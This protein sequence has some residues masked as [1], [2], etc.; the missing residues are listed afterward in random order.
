MA[1]KKA[2]VDALMLERARYLV[3]QLKSVV[4]RLEELA[5]ISDDT[6]DKVQKQVAD[7]AL[8]V[9]M[10]K[11]KP[12]ELEAFFKKPYDLS[13]MP[14][15]RDSWYLRIPRFVDIQ[16]GWLD[17]QT[18]SYN[19]FIVSR[20]MD[21]LGELPE[22]IKQEL[23]FKPPPDLK[24]DG[25]I[26]SGSPRAL[27]EAWRKYRPYL[28][29]R[30]E[31]RIIIN[32]RRSFELIASLVKDGILPFT[33][34]QVDP[35]DLVNRYFDPAFELR[36]YQREAWDIFMSYSN[37]GVFFPASTGKTVL[38]LYLMTHLKAPHL[39]VVPTILLKEQW[40][41]RIKAHTDLRPDEYTV[42][43][44]YSAV[45]KHGEK[46]W[47][48]LIIDECHHQPANQFSK[49]SFIK[50][51]YTLGLSATPQRE[52]KREELI[53]ALTGH[54]VGLGWEHFKQ[55]GI[56]KSPVCHVWIVKNFVAKLARL[57]ALIDPEIKTIVFCDSIEIGKT[58]S[59]RFDIPHIYGQTKK[60]LD[61]IEKSPVAVVSRVGDEGISLPTVG[62]IIEVSWLY[63]C[64]DDA[65]E[66]LT[67]TGWKFFADITFD[68]EI[69]TLNKKEEIEYHKPEDIQR[70]EYDGPMFRFAGKCYDLLVTPE[71]N[72]YIR[73]AH[74]KM[75]RRDFFEFMKAED[76]V[77]Y[78]PST[79]R[80]VEFKRNGRWNCTG[81]LFFELPPLQPTEYIKT[82]LALHQ[83][84][85]R[86]KN[87]VLEIP[88]PTRSGPRFYQTHK[89]IGDIA[90]ELGLNY[91]TVWLW[92]GKRKVNPLNRQLHRAKKVEK[93]P[94]E[95]WLKLLGWYIS[96]GSIDHDRAVK[97]T[98][99]TPDTRKEIIDLAK[100]LGL[101]YSETYDSIKIYS[102]QLAQELKKL[103]KAEDKYIPQWVKEL[104]RDRLRVLLETLLKG[105]GS[106][107]NQYYTISKKLADDVQE[108]TIKCGYG[109]NVASRMRKV[110]PRIRGREI[111][112]IH[113][114]HCVT[115]AR[116]MTTPR[117][118]KEPQTEYYKGHV[119]DV[120]VPN[121][122]IMVRRNGKA[123]WS[124][125]SRRQ[126]LQRFTRLLHGFE[127]KGAGEHHILM[128]LDEY[129]HDRKRLFSVMDKG[130]K[131]E[132]H[133]EGISERAVEKRLTE[134]WRPRR[135]A[136]PRKEEPAAPAQP[137]P[138]GPV[139]DVLNLPGVQR[140]MQTLSKSEQ[141]FW[142]L[143]LQND[144]S[145][146]R[147]DKLP[148][149][150]GYT[151]EDS[152]GHL[153]RFGKLV[154]RGYIEQSKIDR[155]FAYRTNMRAKVG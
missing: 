77:R 146:F 116:T 145:W 34:K 85:I 101:G 149:L 32:K 20:Y 57:K 137:V 45:K 1:E 142:K 133:R 42:C 62:K 49:L 155:K 54:P 105:D 44:Y 31:K 68:D 13:P 71:H 6:R 46:D 23:G 103:G 109:S 55:L 87:A 59:K 37:I 21:W 51:K 28:K 40:E 65:T 41:E 93:V 131:V 123:V 36:P 10:T 70:Y 148:L 138:Q 19:T 30:D 60:R 74:G 104:P 38:G 150:L 90:K 139:A 108:I 69:A 83:K 64:Y 24:L 25:E 47:T 97:I 7:Y 144:G 67:K 82:Q 120:T 118:Y 39:V 84:A 22:K 152:M 14:G 80:S 107:G 79:L 27:E 29:D 86:M 11:L 128:T 99:T 61:L 113:P 88:R 112:V 9:R 126:E 127:V 33:R 121:H 94:I 91:W 53:F 43:T 100:E 114:E 76:L 15:R 135:V 52:D 17:H 117:I 78:S 73:R 2:G 106:Q 134:T 143:L 5:N 111:N 124:G 119:Y 92:L 98:Q 122:V 12:E 130:F 50:R 102:K 141:R 26:L 147:R 140:I 89:S 56:I 66:L 153:I 18:E 132:I 110:K 75:Q 58:I 129:L 154:E 81:Q 72:M 63:G 8:S 16:F 96:E 3:N 48:S 95:L 4:P 151:S 35:S 125:N 115:I 136:R